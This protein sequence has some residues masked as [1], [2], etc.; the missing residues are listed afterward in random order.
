MKYDKDENPF[1][2]PP[3]TTNE[4]VVSYERGPVATEEVYTLT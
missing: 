3:A 1:F 2:G 4:D